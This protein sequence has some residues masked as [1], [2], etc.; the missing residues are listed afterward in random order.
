MAS[1]LKKNSPTEPRKKKNT[2]GIVPQNVFFGD[3]AFVFA[4]FGGFAPKFYGA[5]CRFRS[6]EHIRVSPVPGNVPR[7]T[8]T[9]R[10]ERRRGAARRGGGDK[11]PTPASTPHQPHARTRR[12]NISRSGER[13]GA[14]PLTPMF[15]KRQSN[16]TSQ[17]SPASRGAQIFAKV[18]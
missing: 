1:V 5:F 18:R 8:P 7:K 11:P 15:R 4:M 2:R 17:A 16:E 6:G 10:G 14:H 3:M 9:P 13:A 12:N